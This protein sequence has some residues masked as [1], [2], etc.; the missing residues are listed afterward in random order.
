L[1]YFEHPWLT[2]GAYYLKPHNL[3]KVAPFLGSGKQIAYSRRPNLYNI[4]DAL[5]AKGEAE[6]AG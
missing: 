6:P 3:Q 1:A 4:L 2:S 5:L